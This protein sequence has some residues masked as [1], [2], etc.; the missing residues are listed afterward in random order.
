M[1]IATQKS[2]NIM[3][4]MLLGSILCLFSFQLCGGGGG[5]GGGAHIGQERASD[6]L[7]LAYRWS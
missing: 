4:P 7:E 5:D 3:C 1:T 2:V 6:S